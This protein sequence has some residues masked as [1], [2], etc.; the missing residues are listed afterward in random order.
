MALAGAEGTVT[1][2]LKRALASKDEPE[3]SLWQNDWLAEDIATIL[4]L[5]MPCP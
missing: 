2:H 5:V 4:Q 3:T 1:R